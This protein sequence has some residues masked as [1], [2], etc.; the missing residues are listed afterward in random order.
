MLE[1][2]RS[3]ALGELRLL[4]QKSEM[5]QPFG[6]N[7]SCW[8][9]RLFKTIIESFRYRNIQGIIPAKVRVHPPSRGWKM[10][11]TEGGRE[12]GRENDLD[13]RESDKNLNT[14][15]SL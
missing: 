9:G 2:A 12:G 5:T 14:S 4:E 10:R 3:I 8:C 15:V 6:I 11:K 1:L 13:L 7:F